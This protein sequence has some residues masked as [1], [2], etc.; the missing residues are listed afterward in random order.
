VTVR[1]ADLLDADALR[2]LVLRVPAVEP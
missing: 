2:A 1:P